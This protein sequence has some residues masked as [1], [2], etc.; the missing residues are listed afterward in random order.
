MNNLIAF[1]FYITDASGVDNDHITIRLNPHRKFHQLDCEC[2]ECTKCTER[3]GELV[4]TPNHLQT[5]IYDTIDE[6]CL[7]GRCFTDAGDAYP[8]NL[9]NRVRIFL[10]RSNNCMCTCGVC[11]SCMPNHMYFKII[12]DH[13]DR[14]NICQCRY[15]RNYRE[16]H[17]RYG[18]KLPNG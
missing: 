18:W 8:Q 15:C 9:D 2:T 4:A 1:S 6:P 5:N 11:L 7:C 12:S 10:R 13:I 16:C 17:E 3:Y 14:I